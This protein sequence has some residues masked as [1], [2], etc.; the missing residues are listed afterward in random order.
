M[1]EILIACSSQPEAERGMRLASDLSV[2]TGAH[3]SLACA[4]ERPV[5]MAAAAG[6]DAIGHLSS[7]AMARSFAAAREKW[8]NEIRGRVHHCWQAADIARSINERG[9]SLVIACNRDI[10]RELVT[11]TEAPVWHLRFDERSWFSAR[12][13]RCAVRGSRAKEWAR[14]FAANLGAELATIPTAL[15]GTSADLV[16]VSRDER[17]T[18]MRF[19]QPLVVV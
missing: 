17:S 1:R 9:P 8:L 6:L 11:Y 4:G 10:A 5:A 12:S 14:A 2:C 19:T 13:I 7:V 15:L 16:V 18:V 3:V